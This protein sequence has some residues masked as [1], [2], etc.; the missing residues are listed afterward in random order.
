MSIDDALK[1][2]HVNRS[3]FHASLDALE[4][5]YNIQLT[6]EIAVDIDKDETYYPQFPKALRDSARAMSQ[7]YEIFYCLENYIRDL[8]IEQL[9][10]QYGGDWWNV[11]QPRSVV[12]QV[13]KDNVARNM[14]R[15]QDAGVTPRSQD[16]IDYTTFGELS[17][18]IDANWPTFGDI[19]NSRKGLSGVLARLNLLRGPIAHCSALS[20]DEVLRLRLT[21]A[22]W[23][24]LMG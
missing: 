13:V 5:Q 21:L 1:I 14:Q 2:F 10:A 16:L 17:T 24:R 9:E 3:L 7:H 15:E 19:F 22:D 8:V 11:D 6:S 20:E 18:I 4:E 12:P 23:F